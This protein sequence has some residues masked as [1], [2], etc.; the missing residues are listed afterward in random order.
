[1]CLITRRRELSIAEEDIIV[2]KVLRYDLKS[3]IEFFRYEEDVLYETEIKEL[4]KD[5]VIRAYDEISSKYLNK[6]YE[7]WSKRFLVEG[8]AI[9]TYDGG[10]EDLIYIGEGFHSSLSRERL[11]KVESY[12]RLRK[13]VIPKGSLYY[14]DETGLMVSNRIMMLKEDK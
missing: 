4:S 9:I 8:D 13:F 11:G 3:H 2:W 10:R 14:E 1:M 5:T 6:H 12:L 7:G